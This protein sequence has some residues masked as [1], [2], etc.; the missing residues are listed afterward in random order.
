MM[1][2][3]DVKRNWEHRL[4]YRTGGSSCYSSSFWKSL[5][6]L[7]L[8]RL[9][10][11]PLLIPPKK[12]ILKHRQQVFRSIIFP[13]FI[14]RLKSKYRQRT[15][16]TTR[17]RA[18]TE[19]SFLLNSFFSRTIFSTSIKREQESHFSQAQINKIVAPAV[20]FTIMNSSLLLLARGSG[21]I[22]L[23]TTTTFCL[24]HQ[25]KNGE[26]TRFR[27]LFKSINRRRWALDHILR[28]FFV[29]LC[30]YT[31]IDNRD[32]AVSLQTGDDDDVSY[33]QM[34]V[35][36]IVPSA[37]GVSQHR[38]EPNLDS[39]TNQRAS[40]RIF[41]FCLNVIWPM[42]A[43]LHLG[44]SIATNICWYFSP[45]IEWN[46]THVTYFCTLNWKAAIAQRKMQ[47]W[48]RQCFQEQVS[49]K[50]LSACLCKFTV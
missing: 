37:L 11:C 9:F 20:R 16:N 1:R 47:D 18:R 28:S 19:N 27:L 33:M 42:A 36:C 32:V 8:L 17:F 4:N 50:R 39:A 30:V 12:R 14:G 48:T 26:E 2:W 25:K 35:S 40:D 49:F 21:V 15:E 6:L 7:L 46:E 41:N 44:D 3:V 5:S 10:S 29:R 43:A 45:R 34:F 22:V 13:S 24:K 23:K 38:I 31:Q